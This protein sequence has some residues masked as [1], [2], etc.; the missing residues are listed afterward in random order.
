MKSKVLHIKKVAYVEGYELLVTFLEEGC[1]KAALG[2][3]HQPP[4][5][6]IIES[7]YLP[8]YQSSGYRYSRL[9]ATS[10]HSSS[11]LHSRKHITINSVEYLRD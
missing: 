3:R 10:N 4:L 2:F 8:E 11:I 5:A 7:I 9:S 1:P 6:R